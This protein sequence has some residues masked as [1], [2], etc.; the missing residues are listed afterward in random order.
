MRIEGE[1]PK[2]DGRATEDG[3]S[4]GLG[5]PCSVAGPTSYCSPVPEEFLAK[6]NSASGR[7]V[8]FQLPESDVAPMGPDVYWRGQPHFEE[9]TVRRK[10]VE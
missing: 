9:Y 7:R 8:S 1:L 2:P 3:S 10:W 5:E 6:G 4:V